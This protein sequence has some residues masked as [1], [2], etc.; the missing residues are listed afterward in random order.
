MNVFELI[1]G[2]ISM[3]AILPLG[4]VAVQSMRESRDLRRIQAELTVLVLESKEISQDVQRLQRE[5][6]TE[7]DAAKVGIDETQRTVAHVTAIVEQTA[8][9]VT[10]GASDTQAVADPDP[11]ATAPD[12]S[13]AT[14]PW[15]SR[16]RPKLRHE[17]GSTPSDSQDQLE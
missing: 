17:R 16:H 2:A 15:R 13:R 5:L 12:G 9:K 11:A 3:L 8:D 6:R 7:Q 1:S 14:R 10:A 4:Y